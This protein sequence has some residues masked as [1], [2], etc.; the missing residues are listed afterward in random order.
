MK[1][2]KQKFEWINEAIARE[3]GQGWGNRLKIYM[4]IFFLE[5]Y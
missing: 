3:I 4:D 2:N 5:R 1:I